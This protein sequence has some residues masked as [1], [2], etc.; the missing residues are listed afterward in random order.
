MKVMNEDYIKIFHENG[1]VEMSKPLKKKP[2]KGTKLLQLFLSTFFESDN[3][4]VKFGHF[5]DTIDLV[6]LKYIGKNVSMGILKKALDR[7]GFYFKVKNNEIWVNISS[8]KKISLYRR[9]TSKLAFDISISKYIE[10]TML[11][12]EIETFFQ[13]EY[14]NF[15]R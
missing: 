11:K 6:F 9:V 8:A 4:W 15:K 10:A 14:L 1:S 3:R 2:L 7:K 12:K 5:S 13:K